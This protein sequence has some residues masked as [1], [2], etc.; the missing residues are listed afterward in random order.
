MKHW[1]CDYEAKSHPPKFNNHPHQLLHDSIIDS[2]KYMIWRFLSKICVDTFGLKMTYPGVVVQ[3]LIGKIL[4]ENITKFIETKRAQR[5]LIQTAD[6]CKNKI[7]TLF[8]DQRNK[9]STKHVSLAGFHNQ[10]ELN[11]NYLVV[12]CD[13]NASF[14][15]VGIF[16]IPI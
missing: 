9:V 8:V 16:Q 2:V 6:K 10:E 14:Y 12:C 7:D 3:N 11:G 13:G 15:E 4:L 5:A 1:N